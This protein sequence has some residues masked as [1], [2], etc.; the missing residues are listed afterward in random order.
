MKDVSSTLVELK[1]RGYKLGVITNSFADG[2]MKKKW[3]V[4]AGLNI[5]WDS[6]TTSC[7]T[8]FRKPDPEIYQHCLDDLN[9]SP[10]EGVFVGHER[11]ELEAATKLG[12]TTIVYNGDPDAV[13]EYQMD[14]FSNLVYLTDPPN[15]KL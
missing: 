1:R 9:I 4:D 8:K 13:A 3:L 7:E 5:T 6:F 2:R 10:E 15:N 11:E 14:E 12:I